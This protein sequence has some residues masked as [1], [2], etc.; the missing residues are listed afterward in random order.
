M[1]LLLAI[2]LIV[3]VTAFVAIGYA[4]IAPA[5]SNATVSWL[6]DAGAVA[7]F[8]LGPVVDLSIKLARWLTHRLGEGWEDLSRL[9]VTW[10]SGLY[11]WADLIIVN[12][13][14]WPLW[15]WRVQR[16]LLFVEIPKVLRAIPHAATSVVHSVTTRVIKIERTVVR[17]PKLSKA[18]AHAL[19]AAAVATFIRPFLADLQWLRRHFHALTH[20]I[21]H[22]LPIPTVPTFPNIWK[23]I[24]A[25]ERKL[26]VPVG[27]ALIVAAL[28]RLG[29]GWIRCNK[30][31][32]VGR[33]LCGLDD[34]LIEKFLLDSLA[35]FGLVSVVEFAEGLQ[36][37]EEEAVSIFG[38]LIREWPS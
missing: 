25:L 3:I 13:L 15:L 24:R 4:A 8:F 22:A 6:K 35:I 31:R 23:R 29:L 34:S 16:W 5:L 10:L 26:S 14:E 28:G 18:A 21:D 38:S 1:P 7:R 19:V 32:Q 37:V 30:V 2:P 36:A 33:R 9:G 20:A 12:A 17:L 27:V 11:Q